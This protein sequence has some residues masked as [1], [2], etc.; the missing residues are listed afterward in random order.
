MASDMLAQMPGADGGE[1]LWQQVCAGAQHG[2]GSKVVSTAFERYG[3][4]ICQVD[5]SLQQSWCVA[6]SGQSMR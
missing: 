2:Q 6:C 3:A 5:H 1:H 4:V